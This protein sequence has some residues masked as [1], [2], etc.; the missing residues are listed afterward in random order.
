MLLAATGNLGASGNLTMSKCAAIGSVNAT[1]GAGHTSV[2]AGTTGCS[3]DSGAAYS[4]IAG[5]A[6]CTHALTGGAILASYNVK[7]ATTYSV[8]G[9]FATSG[10]ASTA[11][12]KWEIVSNNGTIKL[13][14]NVSGGSNFT[15]FAELFENETAGTIPLGTIVSLSGRYVRIAQ[16][17]DN[18][19]GVVSATGVINAGDTPFTWARRHLTGEFG[20][21]LYEDIPDPLWE[22]QI[23]DPDWT[24][25]AGQTEADRPM[26]DNP[27]PQQMISVPIE[28]PEY[29]PTQTN[30]PRTDRPEEWTCVGLVG[31]VYVRVDNTVAVGDWVS[32]VNGIGTQSTERTNLFCMEI[33]QAYSA[34]K[35]YGVAFCLL[36]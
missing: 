20:E 33:R 26:I 29:D 34:E 16:A 30:I 18:V 36:K 12:R 13:L 22:A 11:N 14:G 15:D 23:P 1:L 7:S 4:L 9:G 27:I 31:Q 28:N 8:T 10:G 24:P 35:G 5:G 6:N 2:I 21:T 32:P 17:G 3:F 25:T 19:L